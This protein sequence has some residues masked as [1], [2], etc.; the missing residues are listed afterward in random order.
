[1]LDVRRGLLW[2][3]LSLFLSFCLCTICPYNSETV[4]SIEL[5]FGG[6]IFYGVHTDFSKFGVIWSEIKARREFF[7]FSNGQIQ[8]NQL[9][10]ITY[11]HTSYYRALL[12]IVHQSSL[13]LPYVNRL[14]FVTIREVHVSNINLVIFFWFLLRNW[15]ETGILQN[16][17]KSFNS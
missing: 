13:C 11:R 2:S 5:K 14:S 1:M 9:L 16:W 12:I 7:L 17:P 3:V 4:T 15:I 8:W 6:Q 10:F